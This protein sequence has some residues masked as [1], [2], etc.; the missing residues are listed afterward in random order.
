MTPP[1]PEEIEATIQEDTALLQRIAD[2]DSA[3]FQKLYQEVRRATFHRYFAGFE[4]SSRLRG[5][6]AG[7]AR[8]DLEQ[9]P[10]V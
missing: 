5:C 4:R 6:D 1:T 7:G 2:K 3:S 10:S 9:G 8:P